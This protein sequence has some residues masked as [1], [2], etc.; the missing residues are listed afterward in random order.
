MTER[1]RGLAPVLGLA[2]RAL[3]LGSMPG[4]AS[5]SEQRYYAHPR[6]LFWP[7]MAEIFDR[8]LPQDYDQRLQ[9]LSELNIALWDV[10][11][12]CERD[13]SLDAAIVPDSVVPNDLVT[14]L[15]TNP[16]I[17]DVYFNGRAAEQLFKRH[18]GKAAP[19]LCYHR[20][21]STS[22]ANASVSRADKRRAWQAIRNVLQSE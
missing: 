6:N 5:L 19:A 18:I 7:L 1:L 16:G 2:P 11:G 8:E 20:L 14:L 9:M 4:S 22:P 12:E 15:A 17:K 10:V 3:V 13:G 21:P